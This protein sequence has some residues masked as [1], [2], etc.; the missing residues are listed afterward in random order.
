MSMS[1]QAL[2]N[3]EMIMGSVDEHDKVLAVDIAFS[4]LSDEDRHQF[5]RRLLGDYYICM[6]GTRLIVD[7]G[8]SDLYVVARSEQSPCE[9][10]NEEFVPLGQELCEHC[11]FAGE[12]N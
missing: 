10:C 11:G 2:T 9:N 1:D 6:E 7:G 5:V 12:D 8:S 3:I 4:T